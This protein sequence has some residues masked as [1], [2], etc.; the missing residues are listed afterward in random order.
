MKR[1]WRC[2]EAP[3]FH[4]WKVALQG[5]QPGL[6][7]DEVCAAGFR[8]LQGTTSWPLVADRPLRDT[9]ER[10]LPPLGVK[11]YDDLLATSHAERCAEGVA[12]RPPRRRDRALVEA[13]G[14]WS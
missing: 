4:A 1:A 13:K 10:A 3:T 11:R 9:F 12:A 8:S 2:V 5:S 14:A 7:D 6:P